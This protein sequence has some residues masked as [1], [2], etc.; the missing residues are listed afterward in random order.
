MMDPAQLH[1]LIN[2]P[3]YQEMS[4]MTNV[5]KQEGYSKDLIGNSLEVVD[6]WQTIQGEGPFAGMRAIFIRLAGC[7]L[8]CPFCD[9]DYTSKRETL[10]VRMIYQKAIDLWVEI[11]QPLLCT[12]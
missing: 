10:E 4:M 8:Q 9:T 1:H 11:F 7:N 12:V 3:D 5:Q 6:L 2:H